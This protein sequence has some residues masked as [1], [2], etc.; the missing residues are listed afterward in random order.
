VYKD[1]AKWLLTFVPIPTFL[2]LAV[3]LGTRFTAIKETGLISWV[4]QFPVPAG[5]VGLTVIATI[6]IIWRCCSVLVAGPSELADLRGKTDWMSEAFS[7][8]GVGEPIFS[9]FDA[10]KTADNKR[11]NK[12]ASDAEIAALTDTSQRIVALSENLNARARFICFMWVFGACAIVIVAGLA[13][14]TATLPTT[15]DAVTKPTKVSIFMPPGT[16]PSF[17]TTTGCTCLHD[18][19]AIAVS[20][21]WN[22]PTLRLIGK[23]CP[24]GAWTPPADLDA[25][26]APA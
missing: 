8:Y 25:V 26:I 5:A 12:T 21:L 11:V 15:P 4:Y 6:V 19:T 22:M 1:T 2:A 24:S 3:G 10:F 17:T 20:G 7:K 23:G 13:T 14:A 18:T 16:E 9:N